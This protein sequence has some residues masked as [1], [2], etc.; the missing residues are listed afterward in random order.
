MLENHLEKPKKKIDG[1]FYA[2][3]ILATLSVIVCAV[4]LAYQF[5]RNS[6]PEVPQTQTLSTNTQIEDLPKQ[7]NQP[8]PLSSN[9]PAQ[10]P[11]NMTAPVQPAYTPRTVSGQAFVVTK[12]RENVKLALVKVCAI[13]ENQI[14]AW[15]NIKKN[16]AP[17]Q[18]KIADQ[19][20]N[21][22]RNQI[23]KV[24]AD[25]Q[26]LPA[27]EYGINPD[28]HPLE[29]K[30]FNLETDLQIA[31]IRKNYWKSP[32]Y[33]FDGLTLC[34]VSAKTDA[35]GKY[36]LTIPANKR[37]AIA[38]TTSRKVFNSSETYWWLVWA[39]A[40]VSSQQIDLTNDNLMGNNPANAV[41]GIY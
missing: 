31:E 26:N 38:S 7:T 16:N 40:G 33:Y 4:F 30:K 1:W 28:K 27:G 37:Y 9:P 34:E 3:I 5:G 39:Q 13:P 22:I 2:T 21:S 25:L 36:N 20:I 23:Q 10:I 11:V 14:L 29:T 18:I 8:I 41:V 19:K 17:E 12:G 35:D 6:V 24:S 32:E 15:I